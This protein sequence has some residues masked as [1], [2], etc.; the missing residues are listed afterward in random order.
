MRFSIRDL[1]LVTMIVALAV[2]WWVDHWRITAEENWR[3]EEIRTFFWAP[4]DA[5]TPQA[6]EAFLEER[7]KTKWSHFMEIAT[8][9]CFVPG[10]P[11]DKY[12]SVFATAD[13]KRTTSDPRYPGG[14]EYEFWCNGEHPGEGEFCVHVIVEGSPS[15]IR[16]ISVLKYDY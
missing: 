2:G 4:P 10:L 9:I 8:K 5:G 6:M 1:F 3:E 16:D 12:D 15:V 11:A 14:T 7:K 13:S